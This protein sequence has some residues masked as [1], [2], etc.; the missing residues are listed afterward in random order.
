MEECC[1]IL[2][3]YL[4]SLKFRYANNYTFMSYKN[5]KRSY[6]YIYKYV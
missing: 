1:M 4:E 3:M 6:T 5:Q 2:E